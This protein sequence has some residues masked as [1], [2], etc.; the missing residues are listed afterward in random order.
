MHTERDFAIT[1]SNIQG[2]IKYTNYF[3]GGNKTDYVHTVCN[4]LLYRFLTR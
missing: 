2:K 3:F 4:L 1:D